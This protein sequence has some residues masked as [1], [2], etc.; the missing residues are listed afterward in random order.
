MVVGRIGK[1]LASIVS[2]FLILSVSS[3][4]AACTL[5]VNSDRVQCRTNADCVSRGGAFANASCIDSV[6]KADP[7]WEC[8]SARPMPS[9]QPPPFRIAV[10]TTRPGHPDAGRE[11]AGQ[12]VPEDRRRLHDPVST[13]ASDGHGEADVLRGH[14]RFRRIPRGAGQWHRARR[15]ISSILPID[16]DQAVSV[17]L[18]SPAA[19]AGLL[20]QLGRQPA[21]GHGSIV[22]SRPT[23]RARRRRG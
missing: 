17:S 16:R 2:L 23:V 4:F 8:L 20:L 3:L 22:I 13:A 9:P 7:T 15:S 19:Y 6:C 5:I 10:T 14:G 1:N 21:P 11:R 18:A 12:A